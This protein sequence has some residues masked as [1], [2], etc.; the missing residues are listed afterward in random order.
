MTPMRFLLRGRVSASMTRFFSQT[1]AI[2]KYNGQ[3]T[4]RLENVS[5]FL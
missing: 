1:S 4:P 5:L 3:W 2:A